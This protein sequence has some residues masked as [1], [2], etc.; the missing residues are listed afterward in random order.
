MR[1]VFRQR[2]SIWWRL[3]N[4]PLCRAFCYGMIW[5]FLLTDLARLVGHL[6]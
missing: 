6:L 4:D 2:P 5:A 1:I 3:N